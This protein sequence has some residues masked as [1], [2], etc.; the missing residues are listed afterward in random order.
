MGPSKQWQ[1]FPKKNKK[2]TPT[3]SLQ[4]FNVG[5]LRGSTYCLSQRA[6]N[7]DLFTINFHNLTINPDYLRILHPNMWP[8]NYIDR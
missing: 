7:F 3:T 6:V 8:S 2:S 5:Q 4:A 1:I